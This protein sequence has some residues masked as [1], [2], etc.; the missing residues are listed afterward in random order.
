MPV[1]YTHLSIG[2]AVTPPVG[3][4]EGA[5]VASSDERM[6]AELS[7]GRRGGDGAVEQ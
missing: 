3:Y 4:A 2:P 7:R 5:K 1:S 6:V